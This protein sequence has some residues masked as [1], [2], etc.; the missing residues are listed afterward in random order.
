M[1]CFV[2]H[3]SARHPA[4][5]GR[6]LFQVA[7]LS[8]WLLCKGPDQLSDPVIWSNQLLWELSGADKWNPVSYEFLP[9][10]VTESDS[11]SRLSGRLLFFRQATLADR[12]ALA[13]ELLC[14]LGCFIQPVAS[15]DTLLCQT[16]FF[17]K[18]VALRASQFFQNVTWVASPKGGRECLMSP[19]CLESQGCYLIPLNYLLSCFSA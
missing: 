19:P 6:W 4:L 12:L 2:R 7:A 5:L 9:G 1:G 18:W 14:H 13:G 15:S 3:C 11:E 8:G 10:H 17:F 16:N